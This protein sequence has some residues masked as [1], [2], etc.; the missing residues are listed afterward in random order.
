VNHAGIYPLL[1]PSLPVIT[2]ESNLKN[3]EKILKTPK[4]YSE[5]VN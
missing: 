1:M 3:R 5:V 4:G 2:R